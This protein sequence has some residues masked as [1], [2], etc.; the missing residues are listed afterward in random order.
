[1]AIGE[2]RRGG[3]AY[4]GGGQVVY[5]A[6]LRGLWVTANDDAETAQSETDLLRPAAVDDPTF[7]WVAVPFG[8]T[9]VLVRARYD[10]E[11]TVTASPVVRLVGADEYPL[12]DGTLA[13]DGTVRFIRLD[14]RAADAEGVT[15]TLATSG[16]GLL[17][18]G[19]Y[20]YSDPP[21]LDGYDLLG[22]RSV[23]VLVETA[24]D[25]DTGAVAIELLFLN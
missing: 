12:E 17:R 10:A 1:M 8:A 13:D 11:A 20:A 9:R 22:S 2:P 6:S 16:G 24:A 3:V 18:D 23:G 19:T 25:V 5:P 21:T 14:N 7:H 15:L 4:D